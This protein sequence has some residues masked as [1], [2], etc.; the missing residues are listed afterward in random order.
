[1][2]MSTISLL[3]VYTQRSPELTL[4]RLSR[5]KGHDCDL[6]RLKFIGIN[7]YDNEKHRMSK[8]KIAQLAVAIL[9]MEGIKKYLRIFTKP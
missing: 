1:M 8:K 6:V 7:I 4:F 3:S 2:A 5:Q 9:R